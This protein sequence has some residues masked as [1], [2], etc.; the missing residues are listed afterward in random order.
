MY[1]VANKYETQLTQC[2]KTCRKSTKLLSNK[3]SLYCSNAFKSIGTTYKICMKVILQTRDIFRW[4]FPI[5]H[6]D[7][8]ATYKQSLCCNDFF[9][10][11]LSELICFMSGRYTQYDFKASFLQPS[12]VKLQKILHMLRS[13][14][15][16]S[17]QVRM[18]IA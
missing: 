2:T 3:L 7:G 17:E 11:L 9:C 13:Y 18:T 4:R 8:N 6:S 14:I 16:S 10:S 5:L 1:L 15:F 12:F